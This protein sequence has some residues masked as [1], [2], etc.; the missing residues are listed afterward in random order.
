MGMRGRTQEK[1]IQVGNILGKGES[2][3]RT[4]HSLSYTTYAS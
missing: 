4:F 1:T 2:L 3:I